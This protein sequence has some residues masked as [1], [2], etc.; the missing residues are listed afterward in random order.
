[1]FPV[2]Y[3]HHLYIKSNAISVIGLGGLSGCEMLRIPQYLNNQLTNVGEVVRLSHWPRF[4]SS[5]ALFGTNF[6]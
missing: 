1:V 6:C 4:Y 5:D 3:K 2:R